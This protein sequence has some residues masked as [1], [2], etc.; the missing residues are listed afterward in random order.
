MATITVEGIPDGLLACLRLAADHSGR[1]LSRELV[2]QLARSVACEREGTGA[3][4][5]RMDYRCA[6]GRGCYCAARRVEAR[7]VGWGGPG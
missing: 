7:S 2:V 1:S 5:A 3:D 4:R 6:E